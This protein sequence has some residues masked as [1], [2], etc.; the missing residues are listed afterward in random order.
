MRKQASK[1]KWN[2]DVENTFDKDIWGA[3]KIGQWI[4]QK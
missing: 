3:Y 2:K 1:K 4:N